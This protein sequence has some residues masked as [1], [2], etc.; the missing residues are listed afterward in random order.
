MEFDS[1]DSGVQDVGPQINGLVVQILETMSVL[2]VRIR[3]KLLEMAILICVILLVF[4]VALFLYGSFYYSFIPTANFITPVYFFYRWGVY[5]YPAEYAT[6]N[7]YVN[8]VF[9]LFFSK[10]AFLKSMFFK[11][12]PKWFNIFLK[13][14]NTFFLSHSQQ[15]AFINLFI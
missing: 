7:H 15:P 3:Q 5:R 6:L 11:H 1:E 10:Q 13:E 12:R 9:I 2:L 14:E 4:W 8:R